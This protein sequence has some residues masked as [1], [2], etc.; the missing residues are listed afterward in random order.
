MTTSAAS[1][2]VAIIP[3]PPTLGAVK[4]SHV[5]VARGRQAREHQREGQGWAQSTVASTASASRRV[6]TTFSFTLNEPAAV[7]LT[8]THTVQG[9]QGRPQ[10]R[11]EDAPQPQAQGVRPHRH[12]RDA[13]VHG[14]RGAQQGALRRARL[15]ARKLKPGPL[16][17]HD[18]GGQQHR[19]RGA[20]RRC[21]SRSSSSP[22]ARPRAIG[23]WARLA[24]VV[25][26]W[27]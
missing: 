14:P 13:V 12:R 9:P 18:R 27:A 8:F 16:H 22:P 17:G 24:F 3:P 21:A 1:A 5:E 25:G 26:R 19:P 2:P 23:S 7:T 15:A 10:V 4:Q 20:G 6:G 11:G